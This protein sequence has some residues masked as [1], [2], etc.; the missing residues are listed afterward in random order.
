[1]I[2]D[3][4][5]KIK[6]ALDMYY[7]SQEILSMVQQTIES[8]NSE[9]GYDLVNDVK[10][11][12]PKD[13]FLS[14]EEL[15]QKINTTKTVLLTDLGRTGEFSLKYIL[16]LKQMRDYPNQSIDEF[17][18]HP[19]Y[20]IGDKASTRNI[21]RDIYGLDVS[22][23]EAIEESKR[24]HRLQPL[25]D[26]DYLFE[27]LGILDTEIVDDIYTNLELCVKS[28]AAAKSNLADW[29]KVMSVCFPQYGYEDFLNINK[30]VIQ[31]YR[32][33][34]VRIMHESGDVFTRLRY[35]SNN[36]NNKQYSLSDMISLLG[37]LTHYTKVVH[38]ANYDDIDKDINVAFSKCK[39]LDK[40]KDVIMAEAPAKGREEFCREQFTIER[41]FLDKAFSID[42][43][44][45]NRNLQEAIGL[46]TFLSTDEVEKLL[47]SGYS[48][49]D[50]YAIFS[51]SLG[52]EYLQLFHENDVSNVSDMIKIVM[53]VDKKNI[54]DYI[55]KGSKYFKLLTSLQPQII[56]YISQYPKLFEYVGDNPKVLSSLFMPFSID[57]KLYDIFCRVS[58]LD[59]V[60]EHPSLIALLDYS[61]FRTS[62][63]IGIEIPDADKV[64]AN[65]AENIELFKDDP[66]LTK[67][68]IMLD[69]KKNKQIYE[70]LTI[71]GLEEESIDKLDSTIF[72][73]PMD[74]VLT[75]TNAMES[76]NVSLIEDGNLS[77]SFYRYA[78]KIRNGGKVP[79]MVPIQPFNIKNVSEFK[80]FEV[81]K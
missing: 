9:F 4:D 42:R 49:E 45:N 77:S 24:N 50:L 14:E 8:F 76:D 51:N 29:I 80:G 2:R 52:W 38:E 56:E 71:N 48:D 17:V 3:Y 32:D 67:L 11:G 54:E 47:S 34:F 78:N 13:I 22:K 37:Y 61:Q 75:V 26:F 41:E 57:E 43:V 27:M 21:Y 28:D 18:S 20:G 39:I 1:M 19:L 69:A 64:A 7:Q 40:K 70:L 6:Y 79:P 62:A 74:F 31:T 46:R 72:C 35:L 5:K 53:R 33:E 65:V 23:I 12:S 15:T 16:L 58:D 55:K 81:V 66:I 10:T 60:Q 63:M 59:I 68:P 73:L 44:I 30:D 25:H 36:P